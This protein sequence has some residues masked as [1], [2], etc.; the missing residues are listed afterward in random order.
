MSNFIDVRV[1]NNHT[2]SKLENNKE[3]GIIVGVYY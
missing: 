1:V 3:G 2:K